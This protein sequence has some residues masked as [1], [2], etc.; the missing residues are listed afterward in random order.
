M[1]FRRMRKLWRV[2][3]DRWYGTKRH[4]RCRLTLHV[5]ALEE[6]VLLSLSDQP[7]LLLLDPSG[8]EA[9]DVSGQAVVRAIGT[10]V[11]DSKSAA[12]VEVRGHGLV[13]ADELDIVGS[14][15]TNASGHG[16]VVG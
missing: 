6:R 14:P 2:F 13:N 8:K 9:L 16:S 12:A 1:T 11:V 3:R 10:A 7:A 15:G 5:E 4:G